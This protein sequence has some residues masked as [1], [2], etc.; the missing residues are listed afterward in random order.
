VFPIWRFAVTGEPDVFEPTDVFEGSDIFTSGV[1]WEPWTKVAQ[2][3]RKSRFFQPGIVVISDQDGVDASATK[4]RW[5]VDVPDRTDDYTELDVPNTGL[6]L[7]FYPKGYDNIPGG[8][9]VAL[10]FKGGPNGA[11]V[12]HVQRG[13][14]NQ[15]VG[16]EVKITNLTLSGCTVHV[17]NG[18]VAQTRSG[19]NLLV[20]GY[21]YA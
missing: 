18:G 14:V 19:V 21:G 3:N 1:D 13:L 7:L 8:G 17:Y 2:G 20:R 15:T 5:F 9:Q 12:P 11:P 4:F 10:P 16:D 6:D